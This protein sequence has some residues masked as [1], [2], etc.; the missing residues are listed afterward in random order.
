MTKPS[1]QRWTVV[2]TRPCDEAGSICEAITKAGGEP[3]AI[4]VLRISPSK[5]LQK[6]EAQV[7][8]HSIA[9]VQ[10]FVS[11]H[12]A[13]SVSEQWRQQDIAVTGKLF[14]VGLTTA[15]QLSQ[16]GHIGIPNDGEFTS[17]GL[18]KIADLQEV[19][20]TNIAIYRGQSGRETLKQV[21]QSRGAKVTYIE[22]YQRLK[23]TDPI[24][25]T[26]VAKLA[27]AKQLVVLCTSVATGIGLTER[28]TQ[29]RTQ[30]LGDAKLVVPSERVK[31][32]LGAYYSDITVANSAMD[33]DML[34]AIQSF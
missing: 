12:A 20:D 26:M 24:E 18:L 8:A 22:A 32:A 2:V 1:L 7:S 30:L 15:S 29:V 4:P 3:L 34:A 16:F 28:V 33:E 23:I 31:Q 9:D 27:N 19:A 11:Q 14:A 17:E 10:I 13:S 25:G 21:L 6:F 5:D